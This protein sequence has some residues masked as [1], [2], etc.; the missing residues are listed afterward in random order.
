M[1]P[2]AE[3]HQQHYIRCNTNSKC[4]TGSNC[5]IDIKS[6]INNIINNNDDS[7]I[8]DIICRTVKL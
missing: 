5:H 6:N 1:R 7:D 3:T 8:S 4:D 2:A